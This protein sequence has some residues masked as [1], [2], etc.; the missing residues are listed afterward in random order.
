LIDQFLKLLGASPNQ[1]DEL[2]IK[3][4]ETRG[5]I[6]ELR[7]PWETVKHVCTRLHI[8][9]SKFRRRMKRRPRPH[10]SDID[11]GESGR[12]ILI[13]SNPQLDRFLLALRQP[14]EKLTEKK[15]VKVIL[16]IPPEPAKAR[17]KRA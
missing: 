16:R 11:V 8:S 10:P 3:R 12:I 17:K 4:L 14:P 15:T 9:Q 1:I 2:F 7:G 5:Y 13:R 6:V